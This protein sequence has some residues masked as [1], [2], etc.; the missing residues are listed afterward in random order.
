MKVFSFGTLNEI[1]Y[2]ILIFTDILILI[3]DCKGPKEM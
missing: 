3:T 1:G 2:F